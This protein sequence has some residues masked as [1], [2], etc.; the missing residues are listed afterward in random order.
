MKA[1]ELVSNV[2]ITVGPTTL[3]D[4]ARETMDRCN[5]RHL[6]VVQDGVVVGMVSH[7]DTC[8]VEGRVQQPNR[9][10]DLE[11]DR[12]MRIPMQVA[13]IMSAPV[14][15]VDA[16]S[17]MGEVVDM[18]MEYQ[19]SALPVTDKGKLTGMIT[20]TDLLGCFTGYCEAHPY[21]QANRDTV[22][23]YMDEP[24]V[25]AELNN[26]AHIVLSSMVQMQCYYA[27]V[28]LDNRLVG[29]ISDRDL[30]KRLGVTVRGSLEDVP[31]LHDS[32]AFTTAGHLMTPEPL[33]TSTD[34]PLKEA[35]AMMLEGKVGAL[36]VVTADGSVAGFLT[37]TSIMRAVRPLVVEDAAVLV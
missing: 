11:Q 29:I 33:T 25:V 23:A 21:S 32:H 5:V 34:T 37:A 31:V 15:C 26:Y 12:Q 6:P 9:G 14:W 7:R 28:V 27:L 3:L 17:D 19:I 22:A 8:I 30:R 18:M 2:L 20:T 16:A 10:A 24:P 13:S 35:V 36:P 1:S 4:D